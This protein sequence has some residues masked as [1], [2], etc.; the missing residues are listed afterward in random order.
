M[1]TLIAAPIMIPP[2]VVIF[3]SLSV[4]WLFEAIVSVPLKLASLVGSKVRR[5]RSGGERP[6]VRLD[7]VLTRA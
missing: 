7:D 6:H 1:V 4:F 3:A 2:A 5:G